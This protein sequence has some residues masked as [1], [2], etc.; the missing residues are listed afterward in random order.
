MPIAFTALA[1]QGVNV[2]YWVVTTLVITA[3]PLAAQVTLSGYASQAT[4]Q[5]G[6]QPLETV[7]VSFSA[8]QLNSVS[9]QLGQI[10]SLVQNAIIAMPGWSGATIV[11]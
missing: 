2:N 3:N 4:Y 10:Q 11:S 7:S 1:P 6:D 9:T 5:A 8:A